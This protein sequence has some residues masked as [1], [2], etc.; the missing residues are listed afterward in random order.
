VRRT[1]SRVEERVHGRAKRVL[2]VGTPDENHD[3]FPESTLASDG[4][5]IFMENDA[6]RV[7]DLRQRLSN[8]GY[9][10]RATIISGDPRR[11]LYKLSG[12]FD[13]IFCSASYLSVRPML[14]KLL[15]PDGV[16][17]TNGGT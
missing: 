1:I 6:A 12:P 3:I 9:A 14:E 13:V 16:L 2:V 7:A 10:G 15:A 4:T 11:M 17:I 5:I 8:G